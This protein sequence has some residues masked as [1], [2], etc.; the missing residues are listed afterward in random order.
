MTPAEIPFS[1][2][3]LKIQEPRPPFQ[4]V[5]LDEPP[6]I[7]KERGLSGSELVLAGRKGRLCR[8]G[9]GDGSDR[10]GGLQRGTANPPSFLAMFAFCVFNVLDIVQRTLVIGLFIYLF[11][12][13]L[14]HPT[15]EAP[16]AV[17]KN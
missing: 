2:Q 5:S 3:L 16:W 1:I 14:Y 11:I 9:D 8:G 13:F 10:D 17:H 6:C 7:R 15:A 4:M 12:A